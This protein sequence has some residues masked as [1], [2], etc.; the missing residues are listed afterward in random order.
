MGGG[1]RRSEYILRSC[2]H[3]HHART[4]GNDVPNT[5]KERSQ[6]RLETLCMMQLHPEKVGGIDPTGTDL[7]LGP[8][9]ASVS[10]LAGHALGWAAVHSQSGGRGHTLEYS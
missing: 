1:V 7:V 2:E 4:D 9:P 6:S 3:G 8:T 10:V 5:S